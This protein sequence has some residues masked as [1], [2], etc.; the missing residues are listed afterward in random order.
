MS[1]DPNTPTTKPDLA[2]R[3]AA[4]LLTDYQIG[5]ASCFMDGPP[6]WN[7]EEADGL[8]ATIREVI[9]AE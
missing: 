2:D 5:W 7:G 6:E 8:A 9:N 1:T 3:I 4:R